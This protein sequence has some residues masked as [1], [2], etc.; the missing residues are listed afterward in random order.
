M[1]LRPYLA[2]LFSVA[3]A[4]T[5]SAQGSWLDRP[6]NNWN[7]AGAAI[8]AAPR[9]SAPIDAM[10]RPTVRTPESIADRALTRAGWSLFGPSQTYGATTVIMGMASVDGMCRP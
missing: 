4:A 8:P 9:S 6:L 3:F 10:C 5:A 7:R 2:V 1:K